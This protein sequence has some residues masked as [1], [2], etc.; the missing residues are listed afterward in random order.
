MKIQETRCH[1]G[2]T[3]SL[4]DG[5]LV[6]GPG[7]EHIRL[8][9]CDRFPACDSYVGVHDGTDQPK[10][11]PADGPTRKA[12]IRC[13]AAFDV[14]WRTKYKT[15]SQAYA[16]LEELTEFRHIGDMNQQQAIETRCKI[17][18]WKTKEELDF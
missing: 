17:E 12:R 1:C 11:I 5:D 8:Y 4:Q 14:I 10:G 3:A 15:R 2:S 18:K 13:H 6:Y 9:V 7:K 16:I